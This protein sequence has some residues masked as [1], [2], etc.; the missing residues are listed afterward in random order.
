VER[1]KDRKNALESYVYDIRNKVSIWVCFS[2]SFPNL[3][4]CSLMNRFLAFWE[5]SE[6]CNWFWKGRNLS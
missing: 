3:K 6:L 1:T 2:N 4:F 5:V